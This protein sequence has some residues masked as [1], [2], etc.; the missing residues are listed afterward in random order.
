[1]V[2]A[3]TFFALQARLFGECTLSI[4]SVDAV[5]GFVDRMVL[6]LS[7]VNLPDLQ[8]LLGTLSCNVV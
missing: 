6:T 2:L 4:I 7:F 1:L 8:W 3:D 5:V